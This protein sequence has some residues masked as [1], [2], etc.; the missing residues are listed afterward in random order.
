MQDR[1]TVSLTASLL[2]A[3]GA[4]VCCVL[5]LVLITA[6]LGGAWLGSLRVFEPLR[7]LFILVA[8]A[9]LGFAWWQIYRIAPACDPDEACA[10]PVVGR[11][12]KGLFWSVAVLVCGLLISPYLI[13]YLI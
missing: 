10:K 9:A 5:P 4:S 6:G 8:L 11:R 2:G 12:R 7:P 1:S 13:P 3:I